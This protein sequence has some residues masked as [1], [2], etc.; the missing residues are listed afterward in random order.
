MIHLAYKHDFSNFM[1]NAKTDLDA[2]Q[3]MGA[4]LRGSGRPLVIASGTLMIAM[5]APGQVGTE[6]ISAIGGTPRGAS[7]IAALDLE[8]RRACALR[9]SACRPRST[10]TARV[11]SR[12]S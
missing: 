10:P 8:P 2:V 9:W 7:E 11:V 6:D 1:A 12:P 5:V 3:A 4:A